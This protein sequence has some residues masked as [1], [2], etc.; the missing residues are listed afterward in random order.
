[1]SVPPTA[2]PASLRGVARA[3]PDLTPTGSSVDDEVDGSKLLMAASLMAASMFPAP[4]LAKEGMYG[5]LEKKLPALV[6]PAIMVTMFAVAL[7]AAY[8]GLQWRRLRE[9]TQELSKLKAELKPLAALE[10]PS[11]SDKAKKAELD[12]AVA[13]LTATRGSLASQNLRDTHWSLGSVLLGIGT[14]FAIEGPVNTFMRAGKLFPGPH[15]YAGAGCV[16]CWALA[17]ALTPQMQKGSDPARIGHIA[18]NTVGLGL[19]AWQL[20]TGWDILSKVW[21]K[22]PW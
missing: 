12:T 5:L 7:S 3:L 15:L 20:P 10:E 8:T 4:A 16:V 19:F 1:M 6:H 18:F 13:A 2:G 9:I 14:S 21:T 11:A 17:A 22:V